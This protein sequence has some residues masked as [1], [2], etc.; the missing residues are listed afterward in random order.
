MKKPP[1]TDKE[2]EVR[3]LENEDFHNTLRF[4]DLSPEHQAKLRGIR[5]RGRPLS[6]IKKEPTTI[7]LSSIV[8]EEFKKEG[9][10]W[11]TRIDEVLV[12]FVTKKRKQTAKK[13]SK[14]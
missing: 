4:S 12:D 7:R 14:P 8:L 3:S 9:A 5:K 1:L 6:A 2:G 10:G 11:Q 13:S